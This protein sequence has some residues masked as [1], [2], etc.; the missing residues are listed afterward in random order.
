MK[1]HENERICFLGDSITAMGGWIGEITDYLIEKHADKK[2]L[3]FNCGVP[4]DNATN[5]LQRIYCDCLGYFPK[6][7]V[8]MFGMNDIRRDL[9]KGDDKSDKNKEDRKFALEN[10]KESV[11]KIVDILLDAGCNVILC[12]PTLYDIWQDCKN[13]NLIECNEGLLACGKISSKIAEERNLEFVDF[14]AIFKHYMAEH[15]DRAIV[16]PDRVHPNDIGQHIMA[17]T[18]LKTVGLLSPEKSLIT[19]QHQENAERMEIEGKL[20]NISFIEWGPFL[21]IRSGWTES[22]FQRRAKIQ[23]MRKENND[24]FNFAIDLYE[25]YKNNIDFLRSDLIKQTINLY[26]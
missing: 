13:E 2:I 8:V 20:R 3:P 25:K 23:E 1:L 17:E 22:V 11:I 7:V 19:E 18:F 26:K 14:G 6:H 12:S 21:K 5:A 24:Y 9:Y 16:N 4:G 10:Y 15:V